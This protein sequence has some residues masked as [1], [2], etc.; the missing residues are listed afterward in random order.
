MKKI[1]IKQVRSLARIDDRQ[2]LYLKSLGLRRI[3][4]VVERVDNQINRRLIQKCHHL[5][6]IVGDKEVVE[7]KK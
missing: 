5:I 2:R 1:V 7:G 3:G 6:A 4:Q